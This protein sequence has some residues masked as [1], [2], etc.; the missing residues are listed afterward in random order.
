RRLP[1]ALPRARQEG[2][3]GPL[4]GVGRYLLVRRGPARGPQG[5]RRGRAAAGPREAR[6]RGPVRRAA[7]R[8]R[9]RAGGGHRRGTGPAARTVPGAALALLPRRPDPRRGG[10]ATRL[11]AGDAQ[12]PP[13]EGPRAAPRP[14]GAAPAD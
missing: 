4:A 14:A 8:R 5:P 3:V 9:P 2:G 6:G 10:R 11:R 12:A 13:G 7:A 1:R